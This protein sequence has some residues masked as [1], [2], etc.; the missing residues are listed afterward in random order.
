MPN[1]KILNTPTL[2]YVEEIAGAVNSGITELPLE[3]IDLSNTQFEY[4]IDPGLELLI[5]S[6]KKDGQQIPVIVR[7]TRPPYQLICGFRRTREHPGDRRGD[8]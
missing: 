7:G 4:R 8:G 6:I 3:N 1:K 2:H 5:E